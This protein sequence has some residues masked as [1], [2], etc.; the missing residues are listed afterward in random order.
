MTR[1]KKK[2]FSDDCPD[3]MREDFLEEQRLDR[4][5]KE[6]AR[7]QKA[8]EDAFYEAWSENRTRMST[9]RKLD[10]LGIDEVDV[11]W[12]L[13]TFGPRGSEMLRKRY[14]E[15]Q[16]ME[17]PIGWYIPRK[18]G[19]DDHLK[20]W[21]IDPLLD[22]L[23][24]RRRLLSLQGYREFR[25]ARSPRLISRNTNLLRLDLDTGDYFDK[26]SVK[27]GLR[28]AN[29]ALGATFLPFQSSSSGGLHGNM[30][31]GQQVDLDELHECVGDLL[32]RVG[33][34]VKAG[35][36]EIRPEA[37]KFLRAPWGPGGPLLDPMSL[38]PV[39][40]EFADQIQFVR[41]FLNAQGRWPPGSGNTT[42]HYVPPARMAPHPQKRCATPSSAA[43]GPADEM[44]ERGRILWE[45]GLQEPNTRFESIPPVIQHLYYGER[46]TEPQR[47][48]DMIESWLERKHNN[49]SDRFPKNRRAVVAD[50][51]RAV[52][53]HLSWAE[54]EGV[55]LGSGGGH[56]YD[57]QVHLDD[58]D[59]KEVERLAKMLAHEFRPTPSAVGKL[60]KGLE[61]LLLYAKR[62]CRGEW[63]LP[64]FP[65]SREGM[66]K[67]IPGWSMKKGS[68]FYYD[69]WLNLLDRYGIMKIVR[70]HATQQCRVFRLNLEFS[71]KSQNKDRRRKV[72]GICR[73]VMRYQKSKPGHPLAGKRKVRNIAD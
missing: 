55:V 17:D 2:V 37:G 43:L 7:K 61:G 65:L 53:A 58:R 14:C 49:M 51:H 72:K 21:T 52:D 25:C 41:S 19:T 1:K 6:E 56:V 68:P 71:P 10:I 20:V 27:D 28:A 34:P 44:R 70:H 60:V 11:E 48:K 45:Q 42:F 38:E 22:H 69:R 73:R 32:E 8:P 39:D 35:V 50:I 13:E 5:A 31:L 54:E 67:W 59:Y 26:K 23:L 29:A 46:I 12:I 4:E 24:G 47:M 40:L 3:Y 9:A 18:K 30:H 63:S 15:V 33:L 62:K 64:E 36:V 57:P 66:K 16:K